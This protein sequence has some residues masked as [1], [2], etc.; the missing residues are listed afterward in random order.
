MSINRA[1]YEGLGRLATY[2]V[3]LERKNRIHLDNLSFFGTCPSPYLV[4]GA[5]K[6][7][8]LVVD[9]D[10]TLL[11]CGGTNNNSNNGHKR[12]SNSPK[13]NIY[14]TKEKSSEEVLYRPGSYEFIS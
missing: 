2:L 13:R 5:G 6:R 9:L 8:S 11:F 7:Y 12:S 10:E 1:F 4:K 3:E 14:N